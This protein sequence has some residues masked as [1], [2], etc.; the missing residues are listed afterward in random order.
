MVSEIVRRDAGGVV[1]YV[2]VF[3]GRDGFTICCKSLVI[4]LPVIGNVQVKILGQLCEFPG[5]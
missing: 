2:M 1:A 5:P 4:Y 3:F